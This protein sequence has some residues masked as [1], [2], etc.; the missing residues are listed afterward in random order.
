MNSKK[1]Q[2]DALIALLKNCQN[3][4]S[5]LVGGKTLVVR[6]CFVQSPHEI[7]IMS[8]IED[9][10]FTIGFNFRALQMKSIILSKTSITI[11]R[12]CCKILLNFATPMIHLNAD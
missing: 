2:I 8:G 5:V 4:Q 7:Y 11:K 12:M 1:H 10:K 6:P 9:E 3:L